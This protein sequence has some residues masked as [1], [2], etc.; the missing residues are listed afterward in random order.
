MPITCSLDNYL[1]RPN[2][3]SG[4]GPLRLFAEIG[5]LSPIM[6][7]GGALFMS[8]IT[9]NYPLFIFAASVVEASLVFAALRYFSDFIVTPTLGVTT[10]AEMDNKAD[11]CSSFFRVL[12]TSRFKAMVGDGIKRSFPNYPIYYLVFAS[13]YCIQ[14]LMFFGKECSEMGPAYSN[15][16]YMS[17]LG[18]TL[19][20][21]L[22]A[23]YFL[24]YGCDSFYSIMITTVLAA[25]IGYL[26]CNQNVA[27]LGKESVDILF[28][29]PLTQR[30]GMDYI[31]VTTNTS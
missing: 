31:C 27:I 6:L 29:P 20:I 24:V 16:P 25:A 1:D 18:G 5:H 13:V 10:P 23:I 4:G 11:E 21:S 26:I 3:M 30:S 12:T 19:F 2:R 17:I 15:R 7:T 14:A 9:I 28:V 8:G 22:Y